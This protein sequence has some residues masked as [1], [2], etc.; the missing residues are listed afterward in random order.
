MI[1]QHNILFLLSL[2]GSFLLGYFARDYILRYITTRTYKEGTLL[3]KAMQPKLMPSAG[4]PPLSQAQRV[5]VNTLG[6]QMLAD[7]DHKVALYVV[8]YAL[9]WH[10]FKKT[11]FV[12]AQEAEDFDSWVSNK[13]LENEHLMND[14]SDLVE[15]KVLLDQ[16]I[17]D[18]SEEK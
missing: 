6:Q 8:H 12:T 4:D 16:S 1:Y 7:K 17:P 15:T 10:M 3:N 9:A 14:F 18:E 11:Y 5:C 13:V 2:A